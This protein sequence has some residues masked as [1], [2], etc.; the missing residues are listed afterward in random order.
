M[1][2]LCGLILWGLWLLL[3]GC[4]G[5]GGSDA[6]LE[7][8]TGLTATA[9]VQ[10]VTL[11][12]N[13]VAGASSYNLYVSDSPGDGKWATTKLFNITS[14]YTHK[15]L[16]AG[17]Y[18]YTVAA[19][20]SGGVGPNSSE[21]SASVNLV[22]FITSVF[23]NGNLHGWSDA[24]NA[25]GLAA[26][27]AICQSRATVAGRSGNF[28]AWL[29]DASNDAYCRM[30][31]LS[32]RVASK[33][34]QTVL[35]ATAGPWVRTD[36]YPFAGRIDQMLNGHVYSPLRYN[37]F[38]DPFDTPVSYY[39]NT[40]AAGAASLSYS[41]AGWAS[42]DASFS[43][44]SGSSEE[45]A[46]SWFNLSSY[47]NDSDQH[48]LCLQ[49]DSGPSFQLPAGIGKRVF[50]SSTAGRGNL[51]AWTGSGGKTGLAAGDAICQGLAAG[52]GLAN[53]SNF[54]A[55]LSDGSSN[56]IDRL[57]SDGPWV[58]V[59][60]VK[61]AD[62]K[63]DLVDGTIFSSINVTEQGNYTGNVTVWTG[64]DAK[65]MADVNTCSGWTNATNTSAG[66]YGWAAEAGSLWTEAQG[67][68]TCDVD[69]YKLYC[70]ED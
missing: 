24:G 63:A 33:C 67:S 42:S 39:S 18:Y 11:Q 44:G 65:G 20:G 40:N 57:I 28:R 4:G 9:G 70:F 30:H 68:V 55:W 34:G 52:V 10:S 64:T 45:T 12:W 13:A 21:V 50:V 29:S 36:G 5:D 58:R 35:P 7:A 60:G 6:S 26:A 49:T 66:K 25:T 69:G 15:P 37:E 41:C 31:N 43:G 8:P 51:S 56:A 22:A 53:P 48:L 1:K 47:C 17:T 2:N 27:D 14:P 62:S 32:G 54:K 46:G 19:V 59:D 61:V 38:G 16:S 3:A 23:G